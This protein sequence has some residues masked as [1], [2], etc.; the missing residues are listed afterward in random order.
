MLSLSFQHVPMWPCAIG[1]YPCAIEWCEARRGGVR[2]EAP[3]QQR[4]GC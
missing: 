4:Q 1:M 2:T 3:Q